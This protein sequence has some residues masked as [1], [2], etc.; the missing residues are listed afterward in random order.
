MDNTMKSEV[1]NVVLEKKLEN[2]YFEEKNFSAPGELMITITLKEYRELV[3]KV[4]TSDER[5]KVADNDKYERNKENEALKKEVEEL[6]SKLYEL[7]IK[8][9]KDEEKM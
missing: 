9:V 2:Y 5:I 1:K 6:K 8:P 3:Q 7:S 4:A